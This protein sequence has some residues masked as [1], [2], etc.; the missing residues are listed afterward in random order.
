MRILLGN[1]SQFSDAAVAPGSDVL[2]F[3]PPPT[4]TAVCLEMGFTGGFTTLYYEVAGATAIVI[5][6]LTARLIDTPD[7]TH[8]RSRSPRLAASGQ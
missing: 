6:T 7:R 3:L 1:V 2:P 5:E 8:N 4:L